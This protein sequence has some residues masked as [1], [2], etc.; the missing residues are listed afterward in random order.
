MTSVLQ[1]WVMG[2]SFMQQSVLLSAMRNADGVAKRHPSKDLV[3]WFRRCVV[4]SAF[5]GRAL[6]TPDEPGGGSYTG[7]VNNLPKAVDAFI[8]ARDEMSLHYFAHFAHAAEIIGYKHPDATIRF[9][10]YEVYCRMV[11]ALHMWPELEEQMDARLGDN[12]EGWMAR[13]DPSSTC[14]D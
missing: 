10:W 12:A 6:L 3:R 11:H 13:N 4:V 7:P 8:D 14:S 5:D 9:F 2:L 1:N